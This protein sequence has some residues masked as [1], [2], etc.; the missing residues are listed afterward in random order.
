MDTITI[1]VGGDI[2]CPCCGTAEVEDNTLPVNQWKW[3]IRPNK[4]ENNG[5]WWSQCLLCNVWFG[6]DGH[7]DITEKADPAMRERLGLDKTG[8]YLFTYE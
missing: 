7:V 8:R 6:S 5:I 1:I 3:N 4:V 2:F